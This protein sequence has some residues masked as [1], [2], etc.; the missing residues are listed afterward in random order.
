MD[1]EANQRNNIY[2]WYRHRENNEIYSININDNIRT[3]KNTLSFGQ[4]EVSYGG[5]KNNLPERI[6]K[7]TDS[8]TIFGRK[9][10]GEYYPFQGYDMYLY[11]CKLY[12]GESLERDFIPVIDRNNV[13]CLYDKVEG[14]LYYN[15]GTEEFLT[16]LDE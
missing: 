16:N 1:G 6:K 9:L 4:G 10:K 5:V 8:L 12:N 2:P 14:K 3:N 15:Q 13:A 7:N 11:S